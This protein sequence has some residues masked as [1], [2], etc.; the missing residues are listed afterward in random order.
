M[1]IDLDKLDVNNEKDRAVLWGLGVE[2]EVWNSARN[3]W[4]PIQEAYQLSHDLVRV[5][6]RKQTE[7]PRRTITIPQCFTEAPEIGATCWFLAS[8]LFDGYVGRPWE[9]AFIDNVFLKNGAVFAT[10]DDVKAVVA[11]MRGKK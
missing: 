1:K 4:I 3:T 5:Y 9:D 10:E 7:T 6:R 2:I 8:S 11:A